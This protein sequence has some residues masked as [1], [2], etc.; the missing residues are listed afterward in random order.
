M[1]LKNCDMTEM[2]IF[3]SI[4]SSFNG[5]TA[6]HTPKRRLGGRLASNYFERKWKERV[7]A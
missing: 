2:I 1:E 4:Y 3:N 5:V 6:L 7:V